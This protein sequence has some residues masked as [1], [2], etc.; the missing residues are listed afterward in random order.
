MVVILIS[1][2]VGLDLYGIHEEKML[3]SRK[4]TIS[5]FDEIKEIF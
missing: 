1:P 4:I 3:N 5:E 2:K